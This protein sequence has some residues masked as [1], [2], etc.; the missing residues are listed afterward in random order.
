MFFIKENWL[1]GGWYCS[2]LKFIIINSTLNN[3]LFSGFDIIARHLAQLEHKI[4]DIQFNQNEI[5]KKLFPQSGS[6]TQVSFPP[7]VNLPCNTIDDINK[8]EEWL[9]SCE[10]NENTAV[11]FLFC[12]IVYVSW[13]LL[14]SMIIGKGTML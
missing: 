10:D 9:L 14:V 11:S 2:P 1:R 4:D 12:F 7:E 6:Q 5:L 8:L 3:A 13:L